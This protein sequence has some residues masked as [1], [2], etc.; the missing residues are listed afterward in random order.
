MASTQPHDTGVP[1]DEHTSLQPPAFDNA[2]LRDLASSIVG[3]PP[4][5]DFTFESTQQALRHASVPRM[6]DAS[7]EQGTEAVLR[8]ATRLWVRT[9]QAAAALTYDD[10]MAIARELME[11]AQMVAEEAA[12]G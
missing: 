6:S 2:E 11:D 5:R 12:A 4:L 7:L 10:W 3:Q 1:S 8:L 9:N